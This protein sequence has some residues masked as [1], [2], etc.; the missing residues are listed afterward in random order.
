MRKLDRN[1]AR[2]RLV[3]ARQHAA[4]ADNQ[5]AVLEVQL[6]EAVALE[7]AERNIS[8]VRHGSLPPAV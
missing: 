8:K 6:A 7:Q 4:A 1:N 2:Q 3:E 5:V